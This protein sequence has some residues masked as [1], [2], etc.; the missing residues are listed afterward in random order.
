MSESHD[1]N[2]SSSVE[3]ETLDPRDAAVLLSE[4]KRKASVGLELN[5][6][7]LSVLG[8][9]AL[10]IGFGIIW[11]SVRHQ[12]PYQGPTVDA[13]GLFYLLILVIDVVA[14]TTLRRT[15]RGVGGQYKKNRRM[16]AGMGGVGLIGTFTIM[17]ALEHAHVS[18]VVVYGIYPATVPLLVGGLIGAVAASQREDWTVYFAALCISVVAA[19]AAFAGPA[20]AWA[21]SGF[22]CGAVFLV[23]AG[24]KL[25]QRHAR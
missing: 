2:E 14:V 8:S 9:F 15:S 10:P 12:H 19:G 6:L 18:N 11:W 13:I 1:S 17:G 23:C 24:V 16:L 3:E 5:S 7:V 20:G 25:Y 4:T 22:G 21:V